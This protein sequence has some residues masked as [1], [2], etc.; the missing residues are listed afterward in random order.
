[1]AKLLQM[2]YQGSR[3]NVTD[4]LL[5]GAIGILIMPQIS[6]D[7][8][9]IIEII[10][11]PG[12][13]GIVAAS[14][15]DIRSLNATIIADYVDDVIASDDWT[16]WDAGVVTAKTQKVMAACPTFLKFTA[17]NADLKIRVNL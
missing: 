2:R 4:T 13:G 3:Y 15:V 12:G 7:R 9:P 1:M 8:K 5:A 17:T 16:N 10:P 11:G 14:I 6:E